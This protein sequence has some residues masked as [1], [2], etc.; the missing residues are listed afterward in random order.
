MSHGKKFHYYLEI[1]L[2]SQFGRWVGGE[3]GRPQRLQDRTE[4]QP[5]AEALSPPPWPIARWP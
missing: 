3:R 1:T 2:A 5:V 4:G